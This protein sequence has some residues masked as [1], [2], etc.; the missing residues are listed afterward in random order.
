MASPAPVLGDFKL[1]LLA[2]PVRLSVLVLE[3]NNLTVSRTRDFRSLLEVG[4]TVVGE[5]PTFAVVTAGLTGDR[6]D[7]NLDSNLLG[8]EMGLGIRDLEDKGR[9]IFGVALLP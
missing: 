9:R 1:C 5:M 7:D 8:N 2:D 3:S 4:L 6:L